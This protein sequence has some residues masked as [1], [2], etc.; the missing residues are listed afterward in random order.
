MDTTPRPPHDDRRALRT[1]RVREEPMAVGQR[2]PARSGPSAGTAAGLAALVVIGL[3]PLLASGAAVAAIGTSAPLTTVPG[4]P[5]SSSPPAS[6]G[7]AAGELELAPDPL[8]FGE[9]E[10]GQS[11]QDAVTVTAV[12]G[13][14]EDLTFRVDGP[15]GVH[16]SCA[17]LELDAGEQCSFEVR[18]VPTDEGPMSGTLEIY[19][20][21]TMA[22]VEL[23]GEGVGSSSTTDGTSATD[24]PQTTEGTPP[25]TAVTPTTVPPETRDECDRRAAEADLHYPPELQ[26]QV[27]EST[28]VEASATTGDEP[29]PPTTSGGGV[30]TTVVQQPLRCQVRA[31]LVGNDF[32]V[33]PDDWQNAS[34]LGTD[35][36]HWVWVVTP[37]RTGDDLL[38]VLEVQGLRFDPEAGTYV[39]AGEAFQDT[40]EIDVQS[41]PESLWSSLNSGVTGVVTHPVFALLAST[42]GLAFL[43]GMAYR[44]LTT[45][46]TSSTSST[47]STATTAS[48]SSTS[49]ASSGPPDET[50]QQH[51]DPERPPGSFT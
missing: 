4:G 12:G 32:T 35:E 38:L 51:T 8:D 20:E 16:N 31:R 25:T 28:V 47:P 6:T 17:G 10:L 49:A 7:E 40:A 21:T 34:F 33:N 29:A 37:Q 30:V 18:F 15:F 9:V 42:G 45:K 36:V 19:S 14:V 48:T 5:T 50:S 39:E 23:R 41:E 44:R 1:G 27:G 46:S 2:P 13:P 3:V 26:M 24:P 11:K 43:A 22:S